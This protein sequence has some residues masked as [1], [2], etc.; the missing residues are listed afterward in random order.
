MK[1][2]LKNEDG[3]IGILAAIIIAATAGSVITVTQPKVEK[4]VR[5]DVLHQND[6]NYVVPANPSP[7]KH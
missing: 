1:K 5:T 6:P 2:F 3:V 7:K 4:F